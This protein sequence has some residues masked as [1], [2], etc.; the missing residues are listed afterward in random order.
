MSDSSQEI[1]EVIDQLLP[2]TQCRQCQYD[3]CLPYAKAIVENNESINR[4]LPG[5]VK[6][7]QKIA[8]VLSRDPQPMIEEMQRKSKPRQLAVIREAECIGCT[9]CITACPVD[10]IIGAS[11]Q[12][13]TI[14]A[15]VCTGCEL[16]IEPCPVD[17]IDLIPTP[18]DPANNQKQ[19][20]DQSRVR[21]QKHQARLAKQEEFQQSQH[22]SAKLMQSSHRQTLSARRSAIQSAIERVKAKKSTISN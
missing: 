20:A 13:H 16:C 14:I 19:Y 4:C 21:Y 11:K 10:A 17:C 5:G 2:Q 8:S 18:F 6:T 1:I 22:H 15:D 9:K 3:G 7:L 12:M